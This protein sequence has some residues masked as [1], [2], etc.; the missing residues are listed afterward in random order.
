VTLVFIFY[1]LARQ[2]AARKTRRAAARSR[3]SHAGA[4]APAAAGS[5]KG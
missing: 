5:G 1:V 3:A 4:V 2:P